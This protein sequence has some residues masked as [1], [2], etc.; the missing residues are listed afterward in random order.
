MDSVAKET[1]VC[2]V[3]TRTALRTDV[4]PAGRQV[5]RTRPPDRRRIATTPPSPSNRGHRRAAATI[6][7]RTPPP[8]P[9]D[10]VFGMVYCGY[11]YHHTGNAGRRSGTIRTRRGATRP[12]TETT[13][14]RH[15]DSPDREPKQSGHGPLA[16]IPPLVSQSLALWRNYFRRMFVIT[17]LFLFGGGTLI[18]LTGILLSAVF[19]PLPGTFTDDLLQLISHTLHGFVFLVYFCALITLMKNGNG[20]IRSVTDA[21]RIVPALSVFCVLSFSLYCL[22]FFHVPLTPLLETYSGTHFLVQ[23]VSILAPLVITLYFSQAVFCLAAEHRNPWESHLQSFRYVR[24]RLWSVFARMFVLG[25]LILIPFFLLFFVAISLGSAFLAILMFLLFLFFLVFM[26]PTLLAAYLF[27]LYTD[28][29]TTHGGG[30][31]GGGT[32][33]ATS[34]AVGVCIFIAITVLLHQ[35]VVSLPEEIDI[36]NEFNL[37]PNP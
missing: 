3:R 32:L 27:A 25:I 9:H 10:A 24:G 5:P 21:L 14:T 35:G 18:L 23:I 15:G 6:R 31:T 34:V 12:R 29:S 30:S 13:R 36:E 17:L 20:I 33:L 19:S 16:G 8:L 2:G 37:N 1:A 7:P 28:L 4:A 26:L 11:E 22:F